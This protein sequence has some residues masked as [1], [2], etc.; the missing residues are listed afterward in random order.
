MELKP[1]YKMYKWEKWAD[2]Q[3]ASRKA[4][5]S[6]NASYLRERPV[7]EE[8]KPAKATHVQVAGAI[9]IAFGVSVITILIIS[10][11]C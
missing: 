2:R 9:L 5:W 11:T 10:V 3:L 8:P 1:T 7:I 6:M 4:W